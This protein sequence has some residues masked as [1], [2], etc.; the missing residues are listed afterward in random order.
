MEYRIYNKKRKTTWIGHILH[1]NCFL[2]H[3][4][5]GKIK[6]K[7]EVNGS[8]GRKRKQLLDDLKEM[9]GNSKLKRGSTKSYFV[10]NSLWKRLW[11]YHN[12]DY[13]KNE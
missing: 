8:R 12:T 4:I 7:M 10:E 2:N 1:R 13:E 6:R 9:G 3:V 5:E 11:T